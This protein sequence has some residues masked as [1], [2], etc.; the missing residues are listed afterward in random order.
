MNEVKSGNIMR[1]CPV[2]G[3]TLGVETYEGVEVDRCPHCKGVWL[4]AGELQA[5]ETNQDSDFRDI[6]GTKFDQVTAAV[7]M[8]KAADEAPRACVACD[9]ELYQKEYA[10][11]SQVMIDSCP[12]GHGIWLDAGELSRLQMFYENQNDNADA[13]A[14]FNKANAG[15]GAKLMGFLKSLAG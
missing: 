4:D 15:V 7:G 13:F 9:N 2:D 3:F 5:I 12:K 6:P 1:V 14:A 11:S 10:F 8:A